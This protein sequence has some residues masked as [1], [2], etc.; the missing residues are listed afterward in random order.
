MELGLHCWVY[1]Q[2]ELRKATGQDRAKVYDTV[3]ERIG[4]IS[5]EARE[6]GFEAFENMADMLLDPV[7]RRRHKAAFDASGLHFLGSS[8][9]APF[10]DPK[11]R[12]MLLEWAQAIAP[13]LK[14][15]GG[16]HL[17]FSSNPVP[18]RPKTDQDYAAQAE[19]LRAIADVVRDY[20]V[21]PNLHT[22]ARDAADDYREVREMVERLR[23]EEL[24]LGPDLAWL[25]V[26][27]GD[28]V[29]FIRRFGDR[30]EFCHVR[31][32]AADQSWTEAAGEGVADFAALGDALREVG[33]DGPVVFEPAFPDRAPTRPLA[34]TLKR[35]ADHLRETMKL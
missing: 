27:G 29:A 5:L 9:N 23:P 17:G 10:W 12:G 13:W 32:Y 25:A 14:E 19:T 20:G 1:C 7:H 21:K 33:Y 16:R 3:A 30:I 28:P 6:A 34:E 31:D 24:A 22:Y 11:E 2:L 15:L 26:G 18:G 8:L 35:S 4:A